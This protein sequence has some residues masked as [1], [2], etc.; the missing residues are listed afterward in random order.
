M[1]GLEEGEGSGL[2]H[3]FDGGAYAPVGD[4]V[5]HWFQK[6]VRAVLYSIF[7]LMVNDHGALLCLFVGM[8]AD[9]YQ[10]LY[11]PFE[12]V[13]IVIPDNQTAGLSYFVQHFYILIP[14]NLR[15][16]V[17]HAFD[18]RSET[19]LGIMVRLQNRSKIEKIDFLMS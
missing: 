10:G 1:V 19:K 9:V 13:H 18:F 2:G 16:C 5:A 7:T 12:G 11:D 3:H 4:G 17:A 6:V 14:F 15:L 8:V